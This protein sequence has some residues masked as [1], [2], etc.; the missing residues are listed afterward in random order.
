MADDSLR[1]AV[2]RLW[3]VVLAAAAADAVRNNRRHGEVLGF[4]PYDFRMPTLDRARSHTWN[5][6]SPRIL[7]PPTF[8]VG[9]S[10]NIGRLA[11]LASLK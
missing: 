1:E 5:P 9:W 11:R 4:V 3:L 2:R 6:D 7:T 8:G 10:V